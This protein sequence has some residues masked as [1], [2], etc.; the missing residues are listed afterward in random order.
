MKQLKSIVTGFALV[1]LASTVLHSCYYD[2][3]EDLYPTDTIYIA[4][5]GA[6]VYS[7]SND[8]EPIV[9]ASCASTS[10]HGATNG[11]REPLTNYNEVAAAIENHSLETLV[12]NGSMPKGSSL[13]QG[14]KT[15]ILEWIKD[16]YKN[17]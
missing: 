12:S 6:V 4:D 9:K 2:N 3:A 1:C 10:C 13:S 15:A 16:G 8:V 7:F 14:D 11:S 5:T 17:N